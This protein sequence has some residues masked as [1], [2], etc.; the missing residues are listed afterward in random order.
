MIKTKN[1][2]TEEINTGIRECLK[3]TKNLLGASKML[4]NNQ[5][6]MPSAIM[7]YHA[8]EE[9]GK[10]VLLRDKQKVAEYKKQIEIETID[11]FYDHRKKIDAAIHTLGPHAEIIQNRLSEL[12]KLN[13]Y[14]HDIEST[15]ICL[16]QTN[17]M[18]IDYD[19]ISNWTFAKSSFDSDSLVKAFSILEKMLGKWNAIYI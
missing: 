12:E 9:F 13:E 15:R 5:Y 1:I 19:D 6:S 16:D 7:Y 10:A 3:N 17:L 11:F 4:L 18:M 8:L 14:F 2:P